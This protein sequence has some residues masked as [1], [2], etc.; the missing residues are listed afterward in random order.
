MESEIRNFVIGLKNFAFSIASLKLAMREILVM[1]KSD[2]VVAVSVS[3]HSFIKYFA[4]KKSVSLN[5]PIPS[6]FLGTVA[7]SKQVDFEERNGLVFVAY[8]GSQTNIDAINWYISQV[9]RT[10]L[11]SIPD[12]KLFVVGDKS[13]SLKELYSE[14][15]IEFVGRVENIVP[16]IANARIA[17]SPALYG[18][19]FRGKINQ[20]SILKVP[21]IAHPISA[22]GLNYPDSSIMICK[23]ANEWIAA[24]KELYSD[25]EKNSEIAE[26]AFEHSSSFTIEHQRELLNWIY[27]D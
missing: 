17:I 26:N 5:T 12:I 13:D 7:V 20:Y 24:I 2:V 25:K 23:T 15:G 1:R 19:G 11:V 3:D 6:S 16:Y 14:A 8:F 10:V 22:S 18:S 4:K 21:T 27:N 9:H